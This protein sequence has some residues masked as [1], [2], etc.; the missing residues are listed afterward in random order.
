MQHKITGRNK[1]AMAAASVKIGSD[2]AR[3]KKS[4]KEIVAVLDN[5]ATEQEVA[6]CCLSLTK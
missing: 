5:A 2:R 6:G 1:A 3:T 4:L